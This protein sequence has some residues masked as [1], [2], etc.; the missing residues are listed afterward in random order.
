MC[1]DVKECFEVFDVWEDVDFDWLSSVWW[2]ED[3]EWIGW[4]EGNDFWWLDEVYFVELDLVLMFVVC[5]FFGNVF[6][7]GCLILLLI[8]FVV[9]VVFVLVLVLVVM[10][11]LC[12]Y[13]DVVVMVGFW[14]MVG[15]LFVL[16]CDWCVD[17][18]ERG[19]LKSCVVGSELCWVR[20]LGG[21][22]VGRVF[23]WN[24]S[25]FGCLI[26]LWWLSGGVGVGMGRGVGRGVIDS[27]DEWLLDEVVEVGLVIDVLVVI[28]CM[29]DGWCLVIGRVVMFEI[30]ELC[31]VVGGEGMFDWEWRDCCDDNE[32]GWWVWKMGEW[33]FECDWEEFLMEEDWFVDLFL[34]VMFGY[35]NGF[36]LVI[37]VLRNGVDG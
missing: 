20:R 25:V 13:K 21:I 6:F 24:E 26:D 1:E 29:M 10:F 22:G 31:L 5:I 11:C 12:W 34:L 35:L 37:G 32:R 28:E 19:R 4:M 27:V 15:I 7:V 23:C 16:V 18:F 30:V 8:V 9:F 3:K 33:E 2:E 36:C 17:S 14:G